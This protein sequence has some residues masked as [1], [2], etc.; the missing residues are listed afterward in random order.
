MAKILIVDDDVDFIEIAQLNLE[1]YNYEIDSAT[2]GEDM[3][4]KLKQNK[5]DLILLDLMIDHYDSGF[6][7]S[8][9]IKSTEEYKN[10]PIILCTAV[11]SETGRKFDLKTDEE[12]E[13]IKVDAF[14][15]K[16]INSEDLISTVKKL[17]GEEI[18]E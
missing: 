13:W 10:I 6:A 15:D 4:K 16:P 9:K 1:K 14:L 8:H 17:L 5:Y 12:K 2:N 7:Y 18:D 3:F 11:A